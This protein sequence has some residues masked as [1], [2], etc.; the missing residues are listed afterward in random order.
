MRS[1][2]RALS[3]RLLEVREQE[4]AAISRRVHD[5]LGQALTTLQWDVAK[6]SEEFASRNATDTVATGVKLKAMSDT[7][8]SALLTVR[9]VATELRPPMLDQFGLLAAIRWQ[10]GEFQKRYGIAC[11]ILSEREHYAPSH[12]TATAVFRIFQ[13]ILTNVARH[14]AAT[15]VRVRLSED[16]GAIVMIVHDNGRG[17]PNGRETASLGILGMR[18]RAWLLG[19]SVDIATSR[20][21]GTSVSVRIPMEFGKCEGTR[22]SAND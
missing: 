17:I 3:A 7:I 10:A 14:S 15:Q 16:A 19:G 5:E 8:A 1:Q 13:E 18:E 4:R 20:R 21:T 11:E 12:C 6:L 2:L 22:S 9:T